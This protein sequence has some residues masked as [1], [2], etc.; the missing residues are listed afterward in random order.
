MTTRD[1]AGGT[2]DPGA[3]TDDRTTRTRPVPRWV[4]PVFGVLAL[5]TVPWIGY[6][7]V[8][9]PRQSV[10]AHYRSA[11]VGFDIGLV[12]GLAVTAVLAYR[13]HRRVGLA[14][15]ATATL[16]VVDAWFDVTSTPAGP[17]LLASVVLALLVEL[18]LAAVCLWI[19]G[20]AE[21]VTERRIRQLA[22]R[23]R[24]ATERA[25]VAEETMAE[26]RRGW[27]ARRARSSTAAER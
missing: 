8:T 17:D 26:P 9:L 16:L 4:A 1:A 14:A 24:L 5:L 19:A 2:G 13:G 20:N 18:P 6:L 22:L 10:S 15:T 12:I 27:R 3:G 7:A 25:R 21:R 23:A 11:W